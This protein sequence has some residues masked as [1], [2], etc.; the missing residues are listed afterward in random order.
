MHWLVIS[1]S[2]GRPLTKAVSAYDASGRL[3]QE[4]LIYVLDPKLGF[5]CHLFSWIFEDEASLSLLT[6]ST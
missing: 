4:A 2:T 3:E 5:S 1:F 6:S